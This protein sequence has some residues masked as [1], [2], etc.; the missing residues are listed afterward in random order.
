MIVSETLKANRV[1]RRPV[2]SENFGNL[3]RL[4]L[5]VGDMCLR[6]IITVG[7]VEVLTHLFAFFPAMPY[8]KVQMIAEPHSQYYQAL[9]GW[10]MFCLYLRAVLLLI[11]CTMWCHSEC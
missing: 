11:H 8:V 2:I 5:C 10:V 7:G 3:G 6:L 1:H 4:A 9:D